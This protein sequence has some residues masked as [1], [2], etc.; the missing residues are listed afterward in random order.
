MKNVV[1]RLSLLIILLNFCY[2][3]SNSGL[4]VILLNLHGDDD[5]DDVLLSDVVI[6]V[7]RQSA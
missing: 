5:D 6:V 1:Q 3:L 2:S 4:S 7:V